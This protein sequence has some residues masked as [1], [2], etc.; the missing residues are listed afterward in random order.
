MNIQVSDANVIIYIKN[1]IYTFCLSTTSYSLLQ[2][3]LTQYIFFLA[4]V[5]SRLEKV[6]HFLLRALL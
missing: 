1:V 5:Q 2:Y 3:W 4:Q 6:R